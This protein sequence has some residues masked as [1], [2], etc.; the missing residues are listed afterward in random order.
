MFA[1]NEALQ[2]LSVMIPEIVSICSIKLPSTSYRSDLESS[3]N[4]INSSYL[5]DGAK[6]IKPSEPL[7]EAEILCLRPLLISKDEKSKDAREE[8]GIWATFSKREL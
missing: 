4:P 8:S 6:V 2:F 5:N 7:D 3:E 1:L